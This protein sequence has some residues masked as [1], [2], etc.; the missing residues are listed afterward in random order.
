MSNTEMGRVNEVVK[1]HR[2]G[3]EL[4][5]KLVW[6][7]ATQTI[8]EVREDNQPYDGLRYKMEKMGFASR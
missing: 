5:D 6:D 4:A 7:P 3:N 1:N 2:E 8:M